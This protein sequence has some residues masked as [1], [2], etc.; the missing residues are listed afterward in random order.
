MEL[1]LQI[2][3]HIEHI[4][5]RLEISFAIGIKKYACTRSKKSFVRSKIFL[6]EKR[7]YNFLMIRLLHYEYYIEILY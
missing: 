4:F 6:S 2:F 7:P 5:F 1:F 3:L